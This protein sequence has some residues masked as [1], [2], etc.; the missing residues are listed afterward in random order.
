MT[1]R[2]EIDLSEAFD[3]GRHPRAKIGFVQLATEQ[4][5]E[6]EMTAICP[7]GVGL[8]FTRAAIPDSITEAS[9]QAQAPLL[10]PAAATLLPDGS[11]DVICYACTSGSIVIGEERV[12]AELARGAPATRTTTL[13]TGVLRALGV[14][15]ARRVAVATPYLDA[16]NRREADHMQAAGFEVTRIAGLGIEKDSDMVRLRPDFISEFA[17]SVDSPEADAVFISCGALRSAEIIERLEARLGKPVICSN[18][19]MAWDVLRRAGITDAIHGYG[20]LLRDF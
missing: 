10:A 15:G 11:L 17:A 7:A 16:I 13:I 5:V 18:P 9:L 2:A 12:C 4:T 1:A 8:H 3:A 14:L 19:A 20:R 6:S